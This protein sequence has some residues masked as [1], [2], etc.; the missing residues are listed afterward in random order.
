M[1]PKYD[2]LAWIIQSKRGGLPCCTFDLVLHLTPLETSARSL[3]TQPHLQQGNS[4]QSSPSH[5]QLQACQAALPLAHR[6]QANAQAP[7]PDTHPPQ[8]ISTVPTSKPAFV[9]GLH[10]S[11]ELSLITSAKQA[12]A[13]KGTTAQRLPAAVAAAADDSGDDDCVMLS[14]DAPPHRVP[15]L[16]VSSATHHAATATVA[17]VKTARASD[18]A[19]PSA[20]AVG[21]LVDGLLMGAK[22]N[23]PNAAS[24]EPSSVPTRHDLVPSTAGAKS[25]SAKS[26]KTADLAAILAYGAAA[27][28]TICSDTSRG[29]DGHQLDKFPK[30]TKSRGSYQVLL[31]KRASGTLKGKSQIHS[32]SNKVCLS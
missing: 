5:Q 22:V 12:P 29:N 15:G 18:G 28:A 9:T 14:Q 10:T 1:L 6:V 11:A 32:T 13:C 21:A 4:M 3:H 8:V 27:T 2:S 30:A 17:D 26:V 25:G 19:G 23:Q 20:A 16:R 7:G 31:R 24:A